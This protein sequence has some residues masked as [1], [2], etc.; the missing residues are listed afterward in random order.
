MNDAGDQLLT[1][2]A[3]AERS[4]TLVAPFVKVATLSRILAAV[5]PSVPV[6]LFTRWRPDELV[7]GVSDLGVWELLDARTQGSVYLCHHLHAKCYIFDVTASV[8]SANLTAHGLYWHPSPNLELQLLVPACGSEVSDLVRT[9]E[10][11]AVPVDRRLYEE[12]QRLARELQALTPPRPAK[13]AEVANEPAP[14]TWLPQTRQP[15]QLFVVY[16]GQTEQV[17]R[18]AQQTGKEDLEYLGIPSGL[19]KSPFEAAVRIVLSQLPFFRE[20]DRLAETPRR[21]G[22]Y[23]AMTRQYLSEH[24]LERD[25]ADTWQTCLRW[26]THFRGDRYEIVTRHYTEVL[27]RRETEHKTP[28]PSAE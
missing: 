27:R 24:G 15:S 18:A 7:M 13:V 3:Q 25:A 2:A 17:T 16:S 5:K 4:V 9:L 12:F 10:K 26:L 20:V 19:A 11:V 22:E 21:F 6:R 8:G 1:L 23:R 28:S 14:T